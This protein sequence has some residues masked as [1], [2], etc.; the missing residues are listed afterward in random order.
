[1]K[2]NADAIG[3]LTGICKDHVDIYLEIEDD[4]IKDAK[5]VTYGCSG[6]VIS[7]AALCDMI[8]GESI[9]RAFELE[10]RPDVIEFLKEGSK[11]LPRSKYDCC[12]IAIGALKDAIVKYKK[13]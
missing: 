11:G 9:D 2:D 12:S 4:L 8:K 10:V 13:S 1:L 7:A 3:G 5:F 6:A